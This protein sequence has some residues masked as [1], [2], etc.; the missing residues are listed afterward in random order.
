MLAAADA[1]VSEAEHQPEPKP[2]RAD[3]E[4]L[5]PVEDTEPTAEPEASAAEP[6]PVEEPA[7]PGAFTPPP[8]S[9]EDLAAASRPKRFSFKNGQ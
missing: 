9:L 3:S 2:V 4:E 5:E 6:E 7:S 8:S 1:G